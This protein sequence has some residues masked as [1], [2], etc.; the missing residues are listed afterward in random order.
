[1]YLHGYG[2]QR[3]EVTATYWL[4]KAANQGDESAQTKLGLMLKNGAGV[5]QNL[6]AAYV[7]LKIAETTHPGSVL[8]SKTVLRLTVDCRGNRTELESRNVGAGGRGTNEAVVDAFQRRL[9][10]FGKVAHL[11]VCYAGH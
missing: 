7:W 8:S 6:I 11:K 2:V 10:K 4:R 5:P 1:M 3:H 9:L